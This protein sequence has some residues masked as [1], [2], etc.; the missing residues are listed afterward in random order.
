MDNDAVALNFFAKVLPDSG[1]Y[2]AAV[3]LKNGGF[4]DIP[5]DTIEDLWTTLRDHDRNGREVY[6]T[7]ASFR[8]NS[9]RKKENILSLQAL[10]A[11]I[12]YGKAGHANAGYETFEQARD[13][14]K[15]FGQ[16][17]D[18]P[19]PI[20]IKSGGGLQI[21]WPLK[22][23]L[24]L[25][26]WQRYA[27]GLSAA[28]LQHG[29]RV[30]GG[31]TVNAAH[32]MRPPGT[33]N[34]KIKPYRPVEA[35]NLGSDATPLEMFKCI[36]G[37]A[38]PRPAPAKG[39]PP[40]PAH[41]EGWPEDDPAFPS[42]YEP[43][44]IDL[45]V[46]NCGVAESFQRSGDLPEPAWMRLA[47]LFH[48]VRDGQNLFHVYSRQNYAGYDHSE[49]DKKWARANS[50]TGPPLCSG[51][52]EQCGG[53]I[54]AKCQACPRLGV[55]TPLQGLE[56]DDVVFSS[57]IPDRLVS[58]DADVSPPGT[59]K[60]PYIKWDLTEKGFRKP[61]YKNTA[62]AIDNMGLSF[63][64][65]VFHM[66]NF[67]GDKL[68]DD[69][70]LRRVREGIISQFKFDPGKEHVVEAA[71]ADCER[72]SFDPVGDY[73]SAFQWDGVRRLSTWLSDYLGAEDTPLN[74]AFGRKTLVAACRRVRQPGCK[75]D[76]LLVLEG[77][78]RAGKSSAW[79]ILAG[80]ENFSDAQIR[81]DDPKQQRE[82]MGSWIH[83]IAELVGLRRADIESVKN[84]LSRQVDRG[85]S[86]YDRTPSDAPR[87]C[88]FVGTVNPV[89]KYASYLNDPTGG[90]R[91]W[92]VK[93]G[94][95]D[96]EA[97]KRDRDQLWAEASRYEAEGEVIELPRGVY[98]AA[99]EQQELRR[100][101]DPWEDLLTE[102]PG[103]KV[104]SN[105]L[106]QRWIG[107]DKQRMSVYDGARIGA[108]MRKLGWDGPKTLSIEGKVVKGYDR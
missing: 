11:D 9:G 50:L 87:R 36:L 94:R 86:A 53:T 93:I 33:W 77:P 57:G 49:T 10:S 95:I 41:L 47:N 83:E 26:Q 12:D 3:K 7:L 8:D 38:A 69:G 101:N 99:T 90:S 51:F 65:D 102:V 27:N 108:I 34:H 23:P 85:R 13:A 73:L 52:R 46:A 29:F 6:F 100:V 43:V 17:L 2:Y 91:F 107:M 20:T 39:L 25:E 55:T 63:R 56:E 72:N 71:Y 96:L 76:Y 21:H 1:L 84:F 106:M 60:S 28:C 15:E 19:V 66:K 89:G 74:R 81:W 4:Q 24:T 75:F 88:I 30:D 14:I 31:L 37:F 5:C 70:I 40:K 67:S 44:G 58:N 35:T 103:N 48:Y 64:R 78:Q 59:K 45:L 22:K 61:T 104:S 62:L 32:I 97:L 79:R 105:D 82:A 68:L 80:D 92:P 42:R 54:R 18:L 98:A 16:A